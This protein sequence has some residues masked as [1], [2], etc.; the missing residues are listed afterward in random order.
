VHR[1]VAS[2]RPRVGLHVLVALA[3]LV[4]CV[5]GLFG[6]YLV[7]P[8]YPGFGWHQQ[9]GVVIGALMLLI[10][11]L[12]RVEVVAFAGAFLLGASVSADWLR[13]TRGVGIGW[14]QQ[15]MIAVGALCLLIA[16]T[17]RRLAA[18]QRQR[19]AQAVGGSAGADAGSPP[20]DLAGAAAASVSGPA[21]AAAS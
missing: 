15:A 21:P 18:A 10:G 13:L 7:P 17:V 9:L 11:L 14:K 19:S 8:A 12:L 4:L 16:W 2:Q 1:A 3:G 5:V 6:D 20:R